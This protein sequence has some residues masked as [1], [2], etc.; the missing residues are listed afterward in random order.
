VDRRTALGVLCLLAVRRVVTAQ[1][2]DRLPTVGFL[3]LRDTGSIGREFYGRLRELGW[4]EG[5]TV[6]IERALWGERRDG[7]PGLA[8]DLVSRPVAVILAVG[9][10]AIAA[11]RTATDTIPI[12]MLY[13]ADPV[14]FGYVQS[15]ARPGGNVTGLTW[16]GGAF[17]MS[18]KTL[19][20]VKDAF[21]RRRRIAVLWTRD[22]PSHPPYVQAAEAAA[23]RLGMTVLSVPYGSAAELD[24]A[25]GGIQRERAE[26]LV[27][28]PDWLTFPSWEQITRLAAAHRLPVLVAEADATAWAGAVLRFGPR[29]TG[30]PA[31]AAEFVDR[32]LRGAKPG[33]LPVEQ[34]TRYGLVV[35]LRAARFLGLTIPP[36]VLARADEV[37]R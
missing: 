33:D 7:I 22:N 11:A 32:I 27:V 9:P 14:R 8:M 20:V 25:F 5:Q 28:F 31:R 21:P 23:P 16:D 37:I 34:P 4:I 24:Q 13:A 36:A 17:T 29:T 10:D 19:E 3:G 6:R 35:D 2:G 30:M 15:L 18:G 1:T 26:L 12:V